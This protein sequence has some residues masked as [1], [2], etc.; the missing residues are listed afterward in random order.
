[1]KK[2][3]TVVS[4][5]FL[6][7][8]TTIKPQAGGNELMGNNTSSKKI[9]NLPD[10]SSKFS[11]D[12]FTLSSEI[13]MNIKPDALIAIFSIVQIGNTADDADK[14][15]N[16]KVEPIIT[17]LKEIG[18]VEDDIFL[19]MV[20]IIPSY[21][22]LVKKKFSKTYT[23]VP[24]GFELRKNLHIKFKDQKILDKI[25]T[26]CAK[27]EVYDLAKVDYIIKDIKKVNEIL[28]EKTLEIINQKKELYKILN[29]GD[30]KEIKLYS[31]NENRNEYHPIERYFSYTAFSSSSIEALKEKNVTTVTKNK[32]LFYDKVKMKN[33]DVVINSDE[34]QP[35][36]QITYQMI[37]T[38]KLVSKEIKE[39][40][41]ATIVKEQK[42]EY[43]LI[44]HDGE[45]KSLPL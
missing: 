19:D 23:E 6:L 13:M 42:K 45:L 22:V 29:E 7:I 3:S 21:E 17:K 16:Q 38:Y 20:S 27:N 8:T 5:G 40:P 18:I 39:E 11:N 9:V 41:K 34:L 28:Q 10:Y 25:L 30:T 43:I 2:T 44:T 14:I 1:M 37:V 31:I 33:F 32:S 24:N 36:I 26:I 35:S 4:I 12:Y 15:L